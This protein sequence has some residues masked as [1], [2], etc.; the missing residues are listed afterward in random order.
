[1]F[2]SLLTP[3]SPSRIDHP[4]GSRLLSKQG[5]RKIPRPVCDDTLIEVRSNF[6]HVKVHC[7]LLFYHS[8]PPSPGSREWFRE[9]RGHTTV[10][11]GLQDL[12]KVPSRVFRRLNSPSPESDPWPTS[13]LGLDRHRGDLRSVTV[14]F[15]D[16]WSTSV[17]D[18]YRYLI[19]P[20]IS[21][22]QSEG[23]SGPVRRWVWST[24]RRLPSI[25]HL[26]LYTKRKR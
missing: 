2:I 21:I 26:L 8:S 5:E 14:R 24:K 6:P 12:K 23:T 20:N 3:V 19:D 16:R 4:C 7:I 10:F 11:L 18:V 17:V 9:S 13:Y 15:R 22:G 25:L 1:M